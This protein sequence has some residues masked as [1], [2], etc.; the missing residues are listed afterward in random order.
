MDAMRQARGRILSW[1]ISE[2]EA[3]HALSCDT[4]RLLYTWLIAHGDNRGRMRGQP[5]HVMATVF[6]RRTDVTSAQIAGWLGEMSRVGLI[7]WYEVAG[8]RYIELRGW[9][10][11][12]KLSG[13]ATRN[14]DFPNPPRVRTDMS[15]QRTDE[16]RTP[17]GHVPHEVEVESETRLGLSSRVGTGSGPP[18]PDL[19]D[20]PPTRGRDRPLPA[21]RPTKIFATLGLHK[22]RIRPG[23]ALSHDERL[24]R[25]CAAGVD[26]L[27]AEAILR[28]E[29]EAKARLGQPPPAVEVSA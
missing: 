23:H 15:V 13:N 3:V 1:K 26:S 22:P 9:E 20:P 21:E 4:A 24:H 18:E 12:Q 11:H 28:S 29:R 14:S 16:V 8:L 2:D 25:L 27:V 7:S 10:K 19:P 5:E 17:Y 6:P